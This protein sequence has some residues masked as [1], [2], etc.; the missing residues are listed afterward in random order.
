MMEQRK[1]NVRWAYEE[2]SDTRRMPGPLATG[3]KLMGRKGFEALAVLLLMLCMLFVSCQQP[4]AA[5]PED[6]SD[7]QGGS[8]QE[9]TDVGGE[10]LAEAWI[11]LDDIKG[12][13]IKVPDGVAK[14]QYRA[15][16]LF[17]IEDTEADGH[18]FGEQLTWRTF[19]PDAQDRRLANLGYFRQGYWRFEIRTLNRN[20][21]TTMTG[22]SQEDSD[23]DGT[24][25]VY[26]QKGK[27]NIINITLHPDDG[28]AREGTDVSTGKIKFGFETNW[29]SDSLSEQ[30]VRIEVTKFKTDGT[31]EP[32]TTSTTVLESDLKYGRFKTMFPLKGGTETARDWGTGAL[33]CYDQSNKVWN[34]APDNQPNRAY[35]GYS[36][37]WTTVLPGQTDTGILTDQSITSGFTATVPEG[38]IRF[39][40][41]TPD[42]TIE[43]GTGWNDEGHEI[44]IDVFKGG[45]TPGNYLVTVKACTVDRTS[46]NEDKEIVLGGQTMA[47]KVVGGE[48]TTVTGSLLLEKYIQ[49]G[50]S[51]TIP[52]DVSGTLQTGDG[53]NPANF[54]VQTD[55][56]GSAS[57][58]ISYVPDDETLNQ[59]RLKYI[60][61]VNGDQ[62]AG[63]TGASFQ[64]TPS[65]YG[66]AKITCIVMGQA[67]DTGNFGK[68]ASDTVVVRVEQQ[69]GPN[70]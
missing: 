50:L 5:V 68:V 27:N 51:V 55:N 59:S 10:G 49:T 70:I 24:S 7:N 12:V 42:L 44:P 2:T 57:I 66:D 58:T 69:T 45:I 11:S 43:E 8:T 30:Y 26:L 40:A 18:I 53:T 14:Y 1:K 35:Y 60:W 62:I 48:V 37:G 47:V 20:G 46:G 67:G 64:Y 39:Y 13:V 9:A 28:D 36:D 32:S 29:L 25:D 34:D 61:D 19:E 65:K 56:L 6:S 63:Q 33:A 21:Q 22:S 3:E 15:I 41:E 17:S 4:A 54:I 23:T 16:P 31:L 52:D 38:R